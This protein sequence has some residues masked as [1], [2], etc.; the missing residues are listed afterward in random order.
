MSQ[1]PTPTAPE[2][3][4]PRATAV[5]MA[6]AG[7]SGV[8]AEEQRA[9]VSV[10]GDASRSPVRFHGKIKSPLRFREAMGALYGVVGSDLRYVPKDRAA[11]VA[12]QR[13][14]KESAGKS[15]WEA[16]QAHFEWL[17]RNDPTASLIL[18]PIICVHPDQVLFEVFSKDE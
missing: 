9:D 17:Q 2:S 11:Y 10:I 6:Y 8:V 5:T 16:Q 13:M 1:E 3:E 7:V 4:P 18:D 12:F 14:R 15:L